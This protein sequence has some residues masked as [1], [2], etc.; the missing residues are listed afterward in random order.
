MACGCLIHARSSA[1]TRV[2]NLDRTPSFSQLWAARPAH[3][4]GPL[5]LPLHAFHAGSQRSPNLSQEE[6]RRQFIT[7]PSLG[8][9]ACR[10]I[11]TWGVCRRGPAGTRAMNLRSPAE[12]NELDGSFSKSCFPGVCPA[13]TDVGKGV[14]SHSPVPTSDLWSSSSLRPSLPHC[15]Q[16]TQMTFAA[17]ASQPAPI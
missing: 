17:I 6:P 10:P 14:K 3:P 9:A 16:Q 5:H 2:V 7:I 11:C 8:G 12:Q 4:R 1:S 15:V 13:P